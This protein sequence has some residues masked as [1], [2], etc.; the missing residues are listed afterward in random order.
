MAVQQRSLV[1]ALVP[2]DV[3]RSLHGLLIIYLFSLH[4]RCGFTQLSGRGHTA[5]AASGYLR[6]LRRLLLCTTYA[7][8]SYRPAEMSL[9]EDGPLQVRTAECLVHFPFRSFPFACS[10]NAY[11]SHPG[12]RSI[13]LKG[14]VTTLSCA[15]TDCPRD[16]SKL[17][18]KGSS[19]NPSCPLSGNYIDG[20]SFFMAKN[21]VPKAHYPEN[22]RM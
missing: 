6:H 22:V 3:V 15:L 8:L 9:A 17:C 14:L 2:C 5:V 1:P 10:G 12:L 19:L 21:V 7:T 4:N 20:Q 18:R 16:H 13:T 11:M